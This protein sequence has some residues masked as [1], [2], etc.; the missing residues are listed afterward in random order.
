M[1]GSHT[2]SDPLSGG[3]AYNMNANNGNI[4]NNNK[5]NENYARCVRLEKEQSLALFEFQ[6]IYDS[7]RS[8]RKGKRG[9]INALKFEENL[10]QNL[11]ELY[12]SLKN[13]TFKPRRSVCFTVLKPKPRE[14]FAADFRDRIVHHLIVNELE[15]V[16]EPAFLKESFACRKGK[17]THKA[18]KHLQKNMRKIIG[19]NVGRKR[20]YFLQ[21]D[22]QNFFMSINKKTL[23]SLVEKRVVGFVGWSD[24]FKQDLLWVSKLIIFHDPTKGFTQKSSKKI[25]D[26]VPMHKS[27]INV[28]KGTGLPIGNNTSQFFANVY[29]HELDFYVKNVLRCKHYVRY[30][31]DF[32]LLSDSKEELLEWFWEIKDFLK[33]SLLLNLKTEVI[34]L[35]L[36]NGIDFLGYIIRPWSVYVRKWV[37]KNFKK[38]IVVYNKLVVS[39]DLDDFDKKNFCSTKASYLGHFKHANCFRIRKELLDNIA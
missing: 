1:N 34:L 25:S 5:S 4:N 24:S 20:A 38:K 8:C 29:L 14:I 28:E 11:Q 3:N 18:V 7:Y 2:T 27:L 26:L 35:P 32:I 21:L 19:G 39:G 23:F 9:T 17:G 13:R 16:F 10:E 33:N 31:D 37:I 36:G 12:Y 30:V 15:K 6:N 22:V